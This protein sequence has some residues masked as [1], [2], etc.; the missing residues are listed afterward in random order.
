MHYFTTAGYVFKLT[1]INSK[2]IPSA[3]VKFGLITPVQADLMVKFDYQNILWA[4]LSYR[5]LDAIIGIVG[6][7]FR[8][9][10]QIGYAF[11]FTMSKI[12]QY[13]SNTHEVIISYKFKPRKKMQDMKCP[14]WG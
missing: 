13:S 7:N 4:G 8:N 5:K 12:R 9:F 1:K 6:I 3:H 10:L 2:L 14:D 11:D